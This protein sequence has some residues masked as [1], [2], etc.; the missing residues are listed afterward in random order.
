MFD[1]HESIVVTCWYIWWKRREI[2]KEEPLADP[3]RTAF[4]INALPSNY[5][6]PQQEEQYGKLTNGRNL[7]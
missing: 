5:I 3:P 6:W 1:L 4:A 7:Q 2:V